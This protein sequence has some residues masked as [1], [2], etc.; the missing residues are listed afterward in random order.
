MK[1]FLLAFAILIATS[2]VADAQ[3]QKRPPP[4]KPGVVKPYGY[5]RYSQPYVSPHKLKPYINPYKKPYIIP[6]KTYT[7]EEFLRRFF[8]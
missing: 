1:R 2:A 4:I 7:L 3:I 8:W 6:Y 5:R